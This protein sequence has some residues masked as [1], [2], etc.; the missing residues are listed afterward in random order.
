MRNKLK[1]FGLIIGLI[2]I[3]VLVKFIFFKPREIMFEDAILYGKVKSIKEISYKAKLKN[4]E[5]V[6]IKRWRRGHLSD[7]HH[8]FFNEE[9]LPI[10]KIIYPAADTG[11]VS[12]LYI[13]KYNRKNQL[14]NT[15]F[16]DEN[17]KIPEYFYNKK[18]QLIKHQ[19]SL[20]YIRYDYYPNGKLHHSIQVDP[21]IGDEFIN[22]YTYENNFI[23]Y[24]DVYYTVADWHIIDAYERDESGNI[25]KYKLVSSFDE[26]KKEKWDEF[27][28]EFDRLNNWIKCIH[29][30]NK[31]PIYVI[32]REIEYF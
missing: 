19:T 25:V 4:N 18:G 31:K 1:I 15:H 24:L 29:Y 23:K 2:L 21:E 20:N 3:A 7:D 28:Y 32:E 10:K 22:T 8:C 5:V 12:I 27:E 17:P 11:T 16:N 30:R 6:K 26:L 13:Y 9:G 14:I